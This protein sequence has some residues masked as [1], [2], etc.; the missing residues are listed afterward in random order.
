M[1]QTLKI[2]YRVKKKATNTEEDSLLKIELRRACE[3]TIQNSGV[4]KEEEENEEVIDEPET[5]IGRPYSLE[6]LGLLNEEK[7]NRPA[8]RR[9]I[10]KKKLSRQEKVYADILKPKGKTIQFHQNEKIEAS[11][12]RHKNLPF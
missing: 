4:P 3:N 2:I 1:T 11:A 7:G 6:P 12:L 10:Q 8:K 5:A 9:K